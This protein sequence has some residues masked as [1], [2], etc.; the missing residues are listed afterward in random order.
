MSRVFVTGSSSGL[1][2]MTAT[3]LVEQ[4]HDVVLHARDQEKAVLAARTLPQAS[5]VVVGDV[6]SIR[7]TRMLAEAAN[8]H[9]P[10]DAVIH[11]VGIGYRERQRVRTEDGLSHVFAINTLAPFILTALIERPKRLVY[12][13]SGLHRGA[14]TG[15]D[16]L[17][18]ERRRWD[19][20][21]A[22]SETK[23]HDV[24]IAFA[25]ARRWPGVLSNALEPGWVATRMGGHGAPDDLDQAHRTQAWLAASDDPEAA[26]TRGYF[27]H[28]KQR[29]FDPQ[30]SDT[31]LQDQLLEACERLSGVRLS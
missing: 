12:L 21:S 7:E 1:G 31:G 28:M 23:L 13:S 14:T 5:A 11:N 18:W 25:I 27:Y 9:G 16:D 6:A 17:A 15:L 30:A 8:R 22:Y 24:M 4:G 20:A 26:V 10:Y 29:A 19:G 3:L 2:M